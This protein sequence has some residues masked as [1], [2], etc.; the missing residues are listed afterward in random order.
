VIVPASLLASGISKRYGATT[1]LDDVDL[2]LGRG[3]VVAL[4]GENGTGKS[5][6]LRICAGLLKPDTGTVRAGGRI[7]YCPQDP[8]LLDRL[9]AT[10]HLE[11]FAPA[12]QTPA[13]SAAVAMDRGRALLD[14]LHF[15]ARNHATMTKDLSGGNR[16]KLN[17]VLALLADPDIVLLDEPYQGF[18][19]GTYINF[20]SLVDNWRRDGKAVLVVTHLLAQLDLADRVVDLNADPQPAVTP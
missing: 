15:P 14:E 16:Q 12:A 10:E 11:L 3:E 20:W 9:T 13:G 8:G 6:L 7:G 19:H 4:V 5:T 17:L 2:H 18:D 1:V